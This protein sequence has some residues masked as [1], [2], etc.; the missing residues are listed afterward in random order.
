MAEAQGLI[1]KP[2]DVGMAGDRNSSLR[3]S[4]NSQIGGNKYAYHKSK[5]A[6]TNERAGEYV[7]K[8][9]RLQQAQQV[10]ASH[11]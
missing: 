8:E 2:N 7:T 5:P 11:F 6:E 3:Q 9:A 4:A 1:K 10:K